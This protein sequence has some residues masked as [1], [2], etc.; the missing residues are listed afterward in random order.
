M[1]RNT[2][3]V[4]K[5]SEENLIENM[6]AKALHHLEEVVQAKLEELEPKPPVKTKED[7][8]REY[9]TKSAA[10]RQ[11]KHKEGKTTSEIAKFLDIKYQHVRNVLMQKLTGDLND[12]LQGQPGRRA[13]QP[14]EEQLREREEAV[15]GSPSDAE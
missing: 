12:K 1:P 11:L 5:Q 8:L 7:Y 4:R 3:N 6:D 9:G 2:N 10:I 14:S 15:T 13:G